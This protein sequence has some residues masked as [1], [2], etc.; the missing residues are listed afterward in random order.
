VGTRTRFRVT[1]YVHWF[2]C[3]LYI[4]VDYEDRRVT[5][6]TV[7]QE[8]AREIKVNPS[9]ISDFRREVD[10]NCALLGYYAASNGRLRFKCDGTRA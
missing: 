10:Q 3:L 1:L 5:E 2:P 8:V 4:R 6:R 9:A 7:E